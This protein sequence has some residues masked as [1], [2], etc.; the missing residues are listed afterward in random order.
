[1]KTKEEQA[2]YHRQRN[3]KMKAS[4]YKRISQYIHKD[5]VKKV[6]A[7]IKLLEAERLF[8]EAESI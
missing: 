5:D 6:Q 3:A 1:M 4:G 7:Y 2:E 8:R